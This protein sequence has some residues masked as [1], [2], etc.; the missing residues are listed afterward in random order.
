[1][2]ARA[3]DNK[4]SVAGEVSLRPGFARYV[5]VILDG[6]PKGRFTGPSATI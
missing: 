3:S 2:R 6:G 1:M 5:V 4:G